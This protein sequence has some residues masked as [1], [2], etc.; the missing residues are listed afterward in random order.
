M[1]SFYTPWKHE[2]WP[3]MGDSI[4]HHFIPPKKSEK[5]NKQEMA[6]TK[7]LPRPK[8]L[9]HLPRRQHCTKNEVFH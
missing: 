4:C 5:T 6:K 8:S 2:H 1:F 3:E 9:N 7:T